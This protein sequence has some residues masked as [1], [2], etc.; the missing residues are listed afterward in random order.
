MTIFVQ[1]NTIKVI[2]KNILALPSFIMVVNGSL[3]FEV[4]KAHPS[5]IKIIH[6][7]PGL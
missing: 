1:T 3:D 7:A 6:T 4:K 2:L 5:I